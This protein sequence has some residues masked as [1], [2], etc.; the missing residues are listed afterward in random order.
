MMPGNMQ[1]DGHETADQLARQGSKLP[2]I[3]P[4]PALGISAKVARGVIK[5][6]TSRKHEKYWQSIRGQRQAKGFFKD[7]LLNSWGIAQHQQ[8]PAKNNNRVANRTLSFKGTFKPGLVES[9]R[10]VR[11]KCI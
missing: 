8:K 7:P 10:C 9:P 11:S 6:W 4:Q 2:L 5:G 3:G 1:I